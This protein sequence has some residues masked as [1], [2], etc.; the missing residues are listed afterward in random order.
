MTEVTWP[1]GLSPRII[2][3]QLINQTRSMNQSLSGIQQVNSS[4]AQRWR[5]TLDFNTLRRAEVLSYRA[6]MASLEGRANTIRVPVWDKRLEPAFITGSLAGGNTAVSVSHSDGTYHSDKTGYS[7]S[8][9]V[10]GVSGVKSSS[11]LSADLSSLGHWLKPGHYIG[12]DGDVYIVVSVDTDG[13][14]LTVQ[15]RLRQTYTSGNLTLRPSLHCRLSGDEIG[16]LP[17]DLG[18]RG[19]PSLEFVE[20]I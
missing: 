8:G 19:S 2:T 16:D 9:G 10:S 14:E 4:L 5:L 1:T 6:M 11:T 12:V 13:D 7:T 20:V 17:L 3:M 15:P 18:L